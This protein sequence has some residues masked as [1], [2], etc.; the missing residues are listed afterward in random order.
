MSNR[1]LTILD[2]NVGNYVTDWGK[3]QDT[4]D[5]QLA[6]STLFV[7]TASI[8]LENTTGQ[9]SAANPMGLFSGQT[10]YGIPASITFNGLTVFTGYILDV[11][12]DSD[13][14]TVTITIENVLTKPA[15]TNVILSGTN[16]NPV[17][18]VQ[19]ILTNAGITNLNTNSFSSVAA[20][21][22]A[23]NAV[24]GCTYA[25]KDHKTV[26]GAVQ[27]ISQLAGFAVYSY[28]SQI[29]CVPGLPV[30][31]YKQ[32]IDGSVAKSFGVKSY[33]YDVY[34]NQVI[35][36][37]SNGSSITTTSTNKTYPIK[38]YSFSNS[39]VFISDSN[40]A[41]YFSNLFL[42]R[43]A[44]IRN[45]ITMDLDDAYF[46]DIALG[47]I[48]L[49][50]NPLWYITNQPYEVLEVNRQPA[51]FTISVT[52]ASLPFALPNLVPS[53]NDGSGGVISHTGN[54]TLN[55]FTSNG[56]FNPSGT[57][58]IQY[59]ISGSGSSFG[60]ITEN[61]STP[62]SGTLIVS[63]PQSVI[64]AGS[65]NS[66]VLQ[67]IT[68]Q[69]TNYQ[70]PSVAAQISNSGV[71]NSL[72]TLYGN[73]VSFN[74]NGSG[75]GILDQNGNLSI[76]GSMNV[77]GGLN[78]TGNMNVNGT[79]NYNGNPVI[80]S[81]T[82]TGTGFPIFNS[83]Q[84]QNLLF[85]SFQG[86]GNITTTF[87]NGTITMSGLSVQGSG[88]FGPNSSTP[89]GIPI[90]GDGNGNR[91]F[92]SAVTIGP[93]G[94]VNASTVI[95]T[96]TLSG[97]TVLFNNA[98]GNNISVSTAITFPSS[99]TVEIGTVNVPADQIYANDYWA[100]SPIACQI[101]N[102]TNGVNFNSASYGIVSG[103]YST[104]FNSGF[105][106]TASP[107][108]ITY[109]GSNSFI[110][111]VKAYVEASDNGGAAS[112]NYTSTI[113]KNGVIAVS[114]L[115]M[116][117][118]GSAAIA[119]GLTTSLNLITQINTNDYFDIRVSVNNGHGIIVNDGILSCIKLL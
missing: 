60:P 25:A 113:F 54:F 56:T 109:T 96:N 119:Q 40:S 84:A 20:Q 107:M 50:T 7:S 41:T 98:T 61:T 88:V 90:F 69:A 64:V 103:T 57:R 106:V 8:V 115:Q 85:N 5:L 89:S 30:G 53:V 92:N 6:D 21:Y 111:E 70:P 97:N 74:V 86:A 66:V 52:M 75:S 13:A 79:L 94:Q 12:E 29:T 47:D 82:S 62:I 34:A 91:L 67:Y 33:A 81:G 59:S 19:S 51:I 14:K 100:S 112:L 65:G 68:A 48:Y 63:T 104:A 49:I 71:T 93:S 18:L 108:R 101:F 27:E 22:S 95:A 11:Q 10:V 38:D 46:S 114:G 55:T 3:F 87:A 37:L 58:S 102:S 80:T 16:F 44:L 116:D 17:T 118:F 105:T 42:N 43:N 31:S 1:I 110:G 73:A 35:M 72:I 117:T 99:G 77:N 26:L 28:G 24:V 9:F 83:V 4:K 15:S 76:A 78:V 23:N 39:N 32:V 2:V 45:E 36:P